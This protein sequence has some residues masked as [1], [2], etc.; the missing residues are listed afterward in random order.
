[1]MIY[2]A[3]VKAQKGTFPEKLPCHAEFKMPGIPSVI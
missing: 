1:M 2:I 3:M